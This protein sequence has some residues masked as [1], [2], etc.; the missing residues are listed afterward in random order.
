MNE[1]PA[2]R[3]GIIDLG[4]NTARLVI[5]QSRPSKCGKPNVAPRSAI[6]LVAEA[7]GRETILDSLVPSAH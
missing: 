2:Q 4:S 5:M 3:I 6:P 7:F 1:I